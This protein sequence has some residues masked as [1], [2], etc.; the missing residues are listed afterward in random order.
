MLIKKGL[1]TGR[2]LWRRKPSRW[3]LWLAGLMV[4]AIAVVDLAGL[5]RPSVVS[6][7]ACTKL[8]FEERPAVMTVLAL[9]R[10]SIIHQARQHDLPS[11]LL[12]AIL[13]DHQRPQTRGNDYSDCLGS[14]LGAN[15]SLGL[16]QM[17]MGTA[18][19]LDGESFTELSAA[20]YRTLRARLMQPESNI[21]YE[22][23]ELRSLLDRSIRSPG[24]SAP[25]LLDDPATIAILVSE[26]RAG[27]MPTANSKTRLGIRAFSTLE[28]MQNGTMP[29]FEYESDDPER[30]KAGI[31]TYLR[32]IHCESGIFNEGACAGWLQQHPD[33]VTE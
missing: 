25:E 17:R 29:G 31:G 18:A 33:I 22:A 11:S 9:H 27:R 12:A 26:Y 30:V 6:A 1:K 24:I 15:L 10:D 21:E 5:V 16:T 8:L 20:Q 32:N 19:E 14:A 4:A 3:R 28:L 7:A 2:S 23:R 13:V